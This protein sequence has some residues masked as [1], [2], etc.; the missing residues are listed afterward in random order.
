M[1]NVHLVIGGSNSY[2]K[3]AGNHNNN[4]TVTIRRE[5]VTKPKK[6][7]A[8]LKHHETLLQTSI[9]TPLIPATLTI[10][11]ISKPVSKSLVNL[12]QSYL[13]NIFVH[14]SCNIKHII[15]FYFYNI[16]SVSFQNL[17]APLGLK[18]GVSYNPNTINNIIWYPSFLL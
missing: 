18:V 1:C 2:V 6:N 12:L 17:A 8:Y 13:W 10:S 9:N 5:S 15:Q 3:E 16:D 14:C 4:L 11:P 7:N